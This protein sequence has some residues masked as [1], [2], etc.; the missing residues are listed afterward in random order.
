MALDKKVQTLRNAKSGDLAKWK[1]FIQAV[2]EFVEPGFKL[3]TKDAVD[4]PKL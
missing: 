1:I 3:L 2:D 4:G